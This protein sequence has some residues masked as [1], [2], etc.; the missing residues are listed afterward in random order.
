MRDVNE[1]SADRDAAQVR[2]ASALE[3]IATLLHVVTAAAA[4]VLVIATLSEVVTI[5]F[6]TAWRLGE[7]APKGYFQVHFLSRGSRRGL[8]FE[9]GENRG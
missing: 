6:G 5:V 3:R 7:R 8:D 9:V 2:S 1:P 4:I